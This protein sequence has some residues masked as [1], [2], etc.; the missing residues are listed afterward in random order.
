MSTS[1]LT[2][3][4]QSTGRGGVWSY[5]SPSRLNCWLT[6]GLKFKL[7][8]IDGI[9]AP[10]TPALFL[11]KVCHAGLEC[12]Y[13]HRQLGVDLRAAEVARR[14]LESWGPAVDEE[15]AKF[16]SAAEEQSLQRQATELVAAY[17]AQTRADEPRPLAVEATVEV[18]L[19]DP[20]TGEDLG[21][22]LLGIMDL[23][24]D[25]AEGAVIADFKT[26]ARSSEPLEVVH[27]IQLSS[28]AYLFRRVSPGQES[29]LEIRSRANTKTPK[30]EIHRD[31]ARTAAHFRRL[32]SVIR[33]Y[34]DDL[35]ARRFVFRP[36]F[37]C[38][39]CDFCGSHCSRWS[40]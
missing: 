27:E 16:A 7:I 17:L 12:F 1:L 29:G 19:V 6:C 2:R 13:R 23:V 39:M 21:L 5:L 32:F 34:L 18:P 35:D 9:R 26:T 4:T 31:P 37:G 14:M 20:V 25:G 11:G 33:A 28:Y 36:G 15:G 38:G 40:G 10:T 30:V 24:L 8:Y 22:P 3:D